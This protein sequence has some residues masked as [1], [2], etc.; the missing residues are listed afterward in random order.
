VLGE[1]TS[2]NILV[3]IDAKGPGDFLRD[4]GSAEPGIPAFHLQNELD[5]FG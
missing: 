1:D 2:H 4:S 3:D 5:K